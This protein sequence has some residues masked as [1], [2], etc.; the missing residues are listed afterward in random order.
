MPCLPGDLVKLLAHLSP[1]TSQVSLKRPGGEA[2]LW[3][4]HHICYFIMSGCDTNMP[5]SWIGNKDLLYGTGSS[6]PHCVITY[7][8]KESEKE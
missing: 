5:L 8:G 7:M 2:T 3:N 1:I 6:S 4:P